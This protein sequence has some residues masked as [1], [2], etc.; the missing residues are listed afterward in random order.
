MQ[1][2]LIYDQLNRRVSAAL[3]VFGISLPP[4]RIDA[5]VR[6]AVA[7]YGGNMPTTESE[8][9]RL[10]YAVARHCLNNARVPF[11]EERLRDVVRAQ[12]SAAVT[13]GQPGAPASRSSI[14]AS[15]A[16]AKP[17]IKRSPLPLVWLYLIVLAVLL[18]IV[19]VVA[20]VIYSANRD[21][22]DAQIANGANELVTAGVVVGGTAALAWVIVMLL[23]M[24]VRTCLSI[25]VMLGM[26]GIVIAAGVYL[27]QTGFLSGLVGG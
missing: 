21:V 19:G 5:T 1:H 25:A 3:A 24:V 14:S 10:V 6:S 2:D 15:P 27:W 17:S 11:S 22:I 20:L 9:A 16:P 12:A 26:V 7:H 18:L 4:D 8:R 13:A 23:R